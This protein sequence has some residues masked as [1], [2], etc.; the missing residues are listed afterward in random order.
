MSWLAR[1]F[2]GVTGVVLLFSGINFAA[3]VG[4]ILLALPM[5]VLGGLQLL[6]AATGHYPRRSPFGRRRGAPPNVR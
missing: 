2:A 3:D 4:D 6:Y 5:L 1:L